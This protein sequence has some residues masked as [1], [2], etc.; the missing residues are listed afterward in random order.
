M[1]TQPAVLGRKDSAEYLAI[2]LRKLDSLAEQGRIK[3]IKI[4]SKTVYAVK[5]L[6]KFLVDQS[7]EC[8]E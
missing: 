1:V 5:E 7:G 8:N 6:D 3:R 2:S 4:D